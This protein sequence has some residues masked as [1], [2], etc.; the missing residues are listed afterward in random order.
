[1]QP[2]RSKAREKELADNKRLLHTWRQW[3]RDQL[4]EALRGPH[5]AKLQALL[6]LLRGLTLESAERLIGFLREQ[7]W[8]SIDFHTR[9][10]ALHEIDRTVITL[11]C[12]AQLPPFDD[13]LPGQPLNGGLIIR[14]LLGEPPP[15]G[16]SGNC[17]SGK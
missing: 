6:E 7:R 16:R 4:N 1:V 3:H 9:Q 15:D 17:E 10:V 5:G 13:A 8:Q 12:K 2:R 11:R 14:E